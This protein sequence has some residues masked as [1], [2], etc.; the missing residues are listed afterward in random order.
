MVGRQ[1][2]GNISGLI[3][4]AILLYL[5]LIYVLL[6]NVNYLLY[7]TPNLPTNIVDFGRFDSSTILI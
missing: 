6:H 1:T 7:D 5:V 3:I 2:V 4:I